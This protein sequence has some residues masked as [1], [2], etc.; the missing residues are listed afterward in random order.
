MATAPA[1]AGAAPPLTVMLGLNCAEGNPEHARRARETRRGDR[2]LEPKSTPSWRERWLKTW[3]P[4][5]STSTARS[6][7][8][9]PL[10]PRPRSEDQGRRGISGDGAEA[11]TS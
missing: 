6:K 11:P 3:P 4:A 1:A 8:S 10:K 5:R 9:K 7:N 2:G